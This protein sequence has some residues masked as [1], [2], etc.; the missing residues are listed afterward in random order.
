MSTT[1]LQ[2]DG[3]GPVEVTVARSQRAK[4]V[5]VTIKPDQT[6]SLTVPRR[7][8]LAEAHE[9]L[10]SRVPWI[11]RH[12]LRLKQ[13]DEVRIGARPAQI[14]RA[15]AEAFLK[16]RLQQLAMMSGFRSP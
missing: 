7:A 3:L 1:V 16:V 6:V 4:R 12:L 10:Q 8:A 5:S 9:F 11:K 13:S 15:N 2:I 14:N